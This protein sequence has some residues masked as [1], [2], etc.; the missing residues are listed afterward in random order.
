MPRIPLPSACDT[1]PNSGLF[2]NSIDASTDVKNVASGR[3]RFTRERSDG[4]VVSA[5]LAAHSALTETRVDAPP[6][7]FQPLL[8]V[9]RVIPLSVLDQA[10]FHALEDEHEILT[11]P[12]FLDIERC[13]IE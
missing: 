6:C 7:P 10:P 11:N 2:R 1:I 3:R 13:A 9:Q 8:R 4:S 12:R 5:G